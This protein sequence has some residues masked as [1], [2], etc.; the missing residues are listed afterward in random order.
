MP[1]ASDSVVVSKYSKIVFRPNRPKRCT[2]P[3]LAAPT[4]TV[5]KTIGTINM[6]TR[7]RKNAPIGV[8]ASAASPKI[9]PAISPAIKASTIFFQSGQARKKRRPINGMLSSATSFATSPP[10]AHTFAFEP[11]TTVNAATNMSR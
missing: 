4:M 8:M 6:L 3:A 5:E 10:S 9:M 7:R 2:S 11:S 1:I